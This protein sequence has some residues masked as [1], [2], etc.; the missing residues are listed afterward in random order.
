MLKPR[1]VMPQVDPIIPHDHEELPEALKP[2]YVADKKSDGTR[3]PIDELPAFQIDEAPAT[4]EV[5]PA[6]VPN[7]PVTEK[8]P[9]GDAA[10]AEEKMGAVFEQIPVEEKPESLDN[11]EEQPEKPVPITLQPFDTTD[12]EEAPTKEEFLPTML[13]NKDEVPEEFL[14]KKTLGNKDEVPKEFLPKKMLGHKDEMPKEFL[15]K[16]MLGHKD[17]MPKEFLPKKEELPEELPEA[18]VIPILL[19]EKDEVPEEFLPKHK[20]GHK[21]HKKHHGK[22]KHHEPKKPEE[23]P[24]EKRHHIH[25]YKRSAGFAAVIGLSCGALVIMLG[26]L[27][28]LI[29]RRKRSA[30][31]HHVVIPTD[32]N[33]DQEHLVQMQKKGFENPT[34]KF[35]Y[36]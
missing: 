3:E 8:A 7:N 4:E 11:K 15:P 16:K 13:G 34:Y 29:V 27:I 1:L 20:E 35:Y 12:E 5:A 21:G 23:E 9:D 26:I 18:T 25:E 32:E 14:P 2:D 33:D 31:H 30:A 17:E 19:G 28:A 10:V 6:T 24:K 22:K 36:Y